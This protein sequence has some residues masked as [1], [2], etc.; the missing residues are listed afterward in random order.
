[1]DG[2]QE[3]D[4]PPPLTSH[5]PLP[6]ETPEPPRVKTFKCSG[7][8][9]PLTVRGMEQTEAIACE[10][11]GSVIDLKDPNFKV[12][13]TYLSKTKPKSFIPLG[14]RA[15][16]RGEI[17]EMIGYMRRAVTVEGVVYE[18]SE[19]LLFN[20]YKG[21]R[22]LIESNGHWSF[23]KT[24]SSFPK[25]KKGAG[26]TVSYLDQT[27]RHFQT[28][29]AKVVYVIG[30]FYWK[31]RVGETAKVSDYIAPPLILSREKTAGEVVWSVGEYLEPEVIW[32][33]FNLRTSPPARIGIAPNQPSPYVAQSKTVMKIFG[34]LLLAGVILHIF[35]FLTAQNAV[36]FKQN[37]VFRQGEREKALVT[38]FFDLKGGPS[39]V[40]VESSADV[41]NSWLYLHMSLVGEDSRAFDFGREISYYHGVDGGESWSEGSTSDDTTLSAIP[42]GKY[43]LLIEPESAAPVV[44]YSIQVRRDVPQWSFFFLALG[45]LALIPIFVKLRSSR[46]ESRR[47][48]EGDPQSFGGD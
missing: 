15:R 27:F 26:S 23:M 5:P 43:Y 46:F 41:N 18:W 21:F 28:A 29:E 42:G 24:A 47:W 44:N 7:C 36:V 9:G 33:A 12:I 31:V 48:A 13:S 3:P 8:G 32:K 17:F 22:W 34:Y 11:C 6:P 37:Y 14:T 38:D 1:M 20:P 25:G 10:A 19:Y 39:N 2:K 30:E 4:V 16:L 45:A 40:V 35:L